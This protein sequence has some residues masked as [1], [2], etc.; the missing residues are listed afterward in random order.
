VLVRTCHTTYDMQRI[1]EELGHEL[2]KGRSD[3]GNDLSTFLPALSPA[4]PGFCFASN[5]GD[6]TASLILGAPKTVRGW[7]CWMAM[8]GGRV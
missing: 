8:P 5:A 3:F 7:R 6:S 1:L 2:M 4:E